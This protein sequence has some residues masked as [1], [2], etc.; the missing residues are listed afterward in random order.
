[1]TKILFIEDSFSDFT[2][3]TQLI[4][5]RFKGYDIQILP[6]PLSDR[7]D[8]FSFSY[9]VAKIKSDI[10][11]EKTKD[12]FA[13]L[14]KFYESE[15]IDLFIIDNR[16]GNG[17]SKDN[18]GI[19]IIEF[20]NEK[21][22]AKEKLILYTNEGKSYRD[23]QGHLI[24]ER[25]STKA[26]F[27]EKD[28]ISNELLIKH[29][30]DNFKLIASELSL[31]KKIC[32]WC[33]KYLSVS[34]TLKCLVGFN[35]LLGFFLC[36]KD[37]LIY[38]LNFIT[39]SKHEDDISKF[40]QLKSS[41]EETIGKNQ[42]IDSLFNDL[43]DK[44]PNHEN[45]IGALNLAEHI[46][47]NFL[48]FFIIIGFFS[49]YIAYLKGIFDGKNADKIP[50]SEI[51]KAILVLNISKKLFLSSIIA[52]LILSV[53]GNLIQHKMYLKDF[54]APSILLIILI[55]YL[56]LLEKASHNHQ[57]NQKESG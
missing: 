51:E 26:F 16:L 38:I 8:F 46:F 12:F 48:P 17:D 11:T 31:W 6:K 25:I 33:L 40:S 54:I 1:M 5:N 3:V 30:E 14:W 56:L 35:F 41:I 21:G 52:T 53:L 13:S 2:S 37:A 39:S 19:E 18:F 49:Y 36:V 23:S 4:E 55:V 9:M 47:L 28:G 27:I 29:I 24:I 10:L 57:S 43:I 20:L 34:F 32:N 50:T 7:Q 22:I 44:K 42:K 15:K 45:V